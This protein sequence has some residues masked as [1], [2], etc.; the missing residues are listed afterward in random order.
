[1]AQR[2]AATSAVYVEAART[3]AARRAVEAVPALIDTA[4][5]SDVQA[6]GA[7]CEALA[8]LIDEG[9]FPAMVDLI[10][11]AG[12]TSFRSA[13]FNALVA[14]AHRLGA[15]HRA[16]QA[17]TAA[18]NGAGLLAQCALIE[19]LGKLGHDSSLA[20]VVTACTDADPAVRNAAVRALADWPSP[21]A[22]PALLDTAKA[23]AGDKLGVL[24]LRGL[25]RLLAVP[26]DRPPEETLT[27]YREA[28]ALARQ[29]IPKKQAL[30]GLAN[31][32][33]PEALACVAAHLANPELRNEAAATVLAIT[34]AIADAHPEAAE[35]ALHSVIDEA[36]EPETLAKARTALAKVRLA[37]L[38]AWNIASTGTAS[39]PDD[40]DKDGGSHGDQAAIDGDPDTYWD[41]VDGKDMY[42][43]EVTFNEPQRIV[44]ITILGYSHHN[45]A[46]KDFVVLADG[47]GVAS[48]EDAQYTDNQLVVDFPAAACKTLRLAIT[49]YYGSSPAI[50][51]LGIY[52]VQE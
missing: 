17:A 44:A 3:L 48:V 52:A 35:A 18:L 12:T 13:A 34:E 32:K 28:I 4:R 24:A 22:I 31:V 14:A 15:E 23:Q 7:S 26:S 30:A 40:L 38:G 27:Y 2:E 50:R 37:R 47:T 42:I 46:P 19:A 25:I 33:T 45:Y 6:A 20:T 41:E 10:V 43:L 9:H 16:S 51:E 8:A 49:G 39:S 36:P 1:M 11:N 21:Q 5:A 29:D